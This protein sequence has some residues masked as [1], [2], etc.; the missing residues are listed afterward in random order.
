MNWTSLFYKDNT[1]TLVY[2]NTCDNRDP[3]N[4]YMTLAIGPEPTKC[5]ST[6]MSLHILIVQSRYTSLSTTCQAEYQCYI[7]LCTDVPYTS[8]L[9]NYTGHAPC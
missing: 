8:A 3:W 1:V 5:G 2:C 9:S 6:P 4:I 7:I